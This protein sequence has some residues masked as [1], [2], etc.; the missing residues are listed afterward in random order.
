MS[1]QGY[2]KKEKKK[3]NKTDMKVPPPPKKKPKFGKLHLASK[4][5]LDLNLNSHSPDL[6]PA[7]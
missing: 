4:K 3:P 7:Q 1:D 5:N 2:K 6:F